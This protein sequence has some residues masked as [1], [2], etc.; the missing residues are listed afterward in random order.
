MPKTTNEK[1]AALVLAAGLSRRFG[2]N[3]LLADWHG[4][5]LVTYAVDA[6]CAAPVDHV[7]AVTGHEADKAASAIL[8][9]ATRPVRLV[10][11]PHYAE[12]MAMSLRAGI[13][14]LEPDVQAVVVFLGDMPDVPHHVAANVLKAVLEG[15]PAAA[16]VLQGRRGHPAAFHADLFPA[17]RTLSGDEGAKSV[18][19]GLGEA[20]MRVP[21]D[22]PGVL[23]DVDR[24]ARD[25]PRWYRA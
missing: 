12:G 16:P 13:A 9:H 17:L 3:K 23:F 2:A 10:Q 14:A 8:A 4:R 5:P 21:C 6:A 18:F 24:C 7:I 15:A 20:W 22:D 11:A 1:T 25:A 19:S